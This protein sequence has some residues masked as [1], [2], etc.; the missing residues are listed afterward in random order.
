MSIRRKTCE[1]MTLL[2]EAALKTTSAQGTEDEPSS[3]PNNVNPT[4]G[5]HLRD[6]YGKSVF[7]KDPTRPGGGVF[8]AQSQDEKLQAGLQ[9]ADIVLASEYGPGSGSVS[10]NGSTSASASA[11]GSGSGP[12]QGQGQGPTPN[13]A[14]NTGG[15]AP[16]PPVYYSN[17]LGLGPGPQFGS[18]PTPPQ[19]QTQT[20]TQSQAGTAPG[21]GPGHGP[22]GGTGQGDMFQNIQMQMG[23]GAP[24]VNPNINVNL[25]FSQ[26]PNP[27]P[28]GNGMQTAD[29]MVLNAPNQDVSPGSNLLLGTLMA[30]LMFFTSCLM[31]R[32]LLDLMLVCWKVYL[33]VNSIGPNGM[34]VPNFPAQL[35][36]E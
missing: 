4:P 24:N 11:S 29:G 26:V 2:Y 14:G 35:R 27:N 10:V 34:Y 9:P 36:A 31:G 6:N 15:T 17:G 20:Q 12:G 19:T 22:P 21:P 18:N 8:V 33:S 32:I 30:D 13:G 1:T 25:D 7:V 5:V 23:L 3:R 16:P 28:N